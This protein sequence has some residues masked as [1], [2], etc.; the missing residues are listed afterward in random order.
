MVKYTSE[1][2]QCPTYCSYSKCIVMAFANQNKGIGSTA[3]GG[4]PIV[5]ILFLPVIG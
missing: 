1:N 3:E 5:L 4:S 2:G